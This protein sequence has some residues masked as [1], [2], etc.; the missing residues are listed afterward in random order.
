LRAE[1]EQLKKAPLKRSDIKQKNANKKN[2]LMDNKNTFKYTG[3]RI[4]ASQKPTGSVNSKKNKKERLAQQAT[5][6]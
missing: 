3:S 1:N 6:I 2:S 4:S 5:N